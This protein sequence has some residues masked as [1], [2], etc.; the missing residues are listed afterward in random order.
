MSDTFAAKNR[1]LRDRTA[2]LQL[3]IEV[4]NRG[5][6]ETNDIAVKA[7]ELHP[8]RRKSSHHNEKAL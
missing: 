4:S 2:E 7:F 3:E 1:E 8:R 6:T 5:R